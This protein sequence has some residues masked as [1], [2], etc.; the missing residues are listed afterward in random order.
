MKKYHAAMVELH[1]DRCGWHCKSE[2]SPARLK[3]EEVEKWDYVCSFTWKGS[4]D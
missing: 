1:W 3:I 2:E 4:R